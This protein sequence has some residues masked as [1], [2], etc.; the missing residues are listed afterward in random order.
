M[1]DGRALSEQEI[2]AIQRNIYAGLYYDAEIDRLFESIL[3]QRRVLDILFGLF[4]QES[5]L[6]RVSVANPIRNSELA[7]LKE[8]V[9][10]E[11]DQ[12]QR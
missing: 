1:K 12:C 5:P 2:G 7:H 10:M 9:S 6:R 3:V 11:D 4:V 8:L